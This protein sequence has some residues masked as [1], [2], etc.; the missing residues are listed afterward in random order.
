VIASLRS[1]FRRFV[2]A[3]SANDTPP[4]RG[5]G[6]ECGASVAGEHEV[7]RGLAEPAAGGDGGYGAI[8]SSEASVNPP[9]L[10]GNALGMRVFSE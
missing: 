5:H 6:P 7:A 9:R 10:S 4:K 1:R 8:R 2:H 3:D